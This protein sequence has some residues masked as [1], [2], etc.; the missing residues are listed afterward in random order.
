MIG[1]VWDFNEIWVIV[2]G[3]VLF[4]LF[5]EW[6]VM[7]FSGFYLLFLFILLVLI[8]CGVLFEYCY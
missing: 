1:L 6:Y 4:V 7:L 3:V 2:V 8:L 5:F